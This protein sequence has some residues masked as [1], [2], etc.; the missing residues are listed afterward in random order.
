MYVIIDCIK[1]ISKR[2]I[3]FIDLKVHRAQGKL[4]SLSRYESSMSIAHRN[5][6]ELVGG[7]TAT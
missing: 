2:D 6:L 7:N 4:G 5:I 1:Y 3:T